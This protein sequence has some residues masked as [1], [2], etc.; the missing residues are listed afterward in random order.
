[1]SLASGLGNRAMT[2][3]PGGGAGLAR[4]RATTPVLARVPETRRELQQALD[5]CDAASD[6]DPT[7]EALEAVPRREQTRAAEHEIP[8]DEHTHHVRGSDVGYVLRR[9]RLRRRH[10]GTGEWDP[11]RAAPPRPGH[12]FRGRRIGEDRMIDGTPFKLT[13]SHGRWGIIY[14]S[15]YTPF[16][17]AA[18][19]A[20]AR[21]EERGQPYRA[22]AARGVTVM[23]E[24]GVAAINTYDGMVFTLGPGYAGGRLAGV[25][26]TLRGTPAGNAIATVPYLSDL[27]FNGNEDI[28]LDVTRCCGSCR[29]S[30]TSSRSTS[31]RRG[32]STSS[33]A[34]GS[35]A[36][37]PRRRATGSQP[38]RSPR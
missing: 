4:F 36:A 11:R 23:H 19:R 24:G 32:C 12:T 7:V 26:G 1:M 15:N 25:L 17:A 18:E 29:S 2:R 28:R 13:R 30:S 20:A 9:A 21:F 14:M 10:F 5:A 6:L 37:A 33:S 8:I 31:P 34:T 22:A 35:P 27:R 38:R 3:H 16:R